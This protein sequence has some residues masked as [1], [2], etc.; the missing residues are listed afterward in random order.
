MSEQAMRETAPE[1]PR[2]RSSYQNWIEVKLEQFT[3]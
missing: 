2:V 1:I 3:G